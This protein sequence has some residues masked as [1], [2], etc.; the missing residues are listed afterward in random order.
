[1]VCK[2][3]SLF[4]EANRYRLIGRSNELVNNLSHVIQLALPDN[5]GAE[6]VPT[7]VFTVKLKTTDNDWI[8]QENEAPEPYAQL[9]MYCHRMNEA[10]E[11][12]NNSITRRLVGCRSEQARSDIRQFKMYID[13]PLANLTTSGQDEYQNETVKQMVSE[14]KLVISRQFKVDSDN[15]DLKREFRQ[16]ILNGLQYPR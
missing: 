9:D 12:V 13:L 3:P 16:D 15:V 2:R 5:V 11:A 6:V 14:W 1:M 10:T 7:S 8:V 4:L